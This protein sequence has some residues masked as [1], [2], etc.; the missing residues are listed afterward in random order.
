MRFLSLILA[1][2]MSVSALAQEE[3]ELESPYVF[4]W[5]KDAIVTG[6]GLGVFG[7]GSYMHL[8][9]QGLSLAEVNALNIYDINA[10]DRSA[11]DRWS[12]TAANVSDGF[13]IG[14]MLLPFAMTGSKRARQDW[15][16]IAFMYAE[17]GL[18]N[19]GLT[20]LT[21]GLAKRVRPYAYNPEAPL[22][23]R[24]KSGT[25]ASFF[26]G[27]TSTSAAF[28][29]LTAKLFHDY[30]DNNTA[31]ALVW[32]AAALIPATTGYLRYHAGKHFPTDI[33]TGYIV[34]GAIGYLVPFLH[35]KKLYTERLSVLPYSGF[36]GTG[37]YLSY[38]L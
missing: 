18:Y 31:K 28:C 1:A 26:S 36:N 13:M 6:V 29:F 4:N 21:K 32:T 7:A 30:S 34:G 3:P 24:M 37:V 15:K 20:E 5:K 17:V 22:S 23:E 12:P 25:R 14:S 8:T 38:K 19:I 10:F 16:V 11:T 9:Q 33:I 2:L 27:H 35:R